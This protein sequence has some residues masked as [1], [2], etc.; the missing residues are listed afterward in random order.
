L[1][2][3]PL[4]AAYAALAAVCFF[5]GTIYL[6]IRVALESLPPLVL[7]SSRFLISGG[8]LLALARW[9]GAPWPGRRQLP[10]NAI[11]GVLILGVGNC[12]LTIAQLWVPSGLAALMIT[13]SPFWMVGIEASMPGGERLRGATVAGMLV[14]LAGTALLLAPELTGSDGGRGLTEGFLL[15][16]LGCA[17]WS[18]GSIYQRRRSAA[19]H[20]LM[21]SALQQLAA[22]LFFLP[23]ALLIPHG[24]VRWS[25]SGVAAVV[26][27]ILFGSIVGY[28][29]YL[30]ALRHLP[31]AVVSIYSYVNPVVAVTL[32]WLFYREPF[33]LREAAAMA[34][35]FAG[36]ALVKLSSPRERASMLAEHARAQRSSQRG[37]DREGKKTEQQGEA[38]FERIAHDFQ[39]AGRHLGRQPGLISQGAFERIL[40]SRHQ[41]QCDRHED[42]AD[43]EGEQAGHPAQ[44]E[45]GAR[46]ERFAGAAVVQVDGQSAAT[47][48]GEQR[49][50]G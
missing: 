23:L 10:V 1:R 16:Q 12:C 48:Q 22:G 30:Y 39:D 5:W 47:Q 38:E 13:V 3:D 24:P 28:S 6:G 33:G 7:V 35:I 42:H 19:E 21:S 2:R 43:E 11:A 4:V 36:V 18:F 49:Q 17:S 40:T 25:V 45:A 9:R 50:P 29:A 15:L 31:V 44:L 37:R 26:Y 46:G 27:L 34:V 14:G 32:G 20:P 41:G 8:L